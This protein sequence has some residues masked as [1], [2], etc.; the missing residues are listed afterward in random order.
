MRQLKYDYKKGETYPGVSFINFWNLYFTDYNLKAAIF[1]SCLEVA[2][3]FSW[4]NLFDIWKLY[5]Y[6]SPDKTK[7]YQNYKI[8]PPTQFL[9]AFSIAC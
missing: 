1:V 2:E 6:E 4:L 3:N 9:T 8:Y 5:K 7:M